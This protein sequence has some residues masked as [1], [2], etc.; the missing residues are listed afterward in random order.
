MKKIILKKK[1]KIKKMIFN[2]FYD[3]YILKNVK[4]SENLENYGLKYDTLHILE[5][6]IKENI[7]TLN[8][9]EVFKNVSMMVSFFKDINFYE[10]YACLISDN[11]SISNYV[12]HNY[13]PEDIKTLGLRMEDIIEGDIL[14]KDI[15]KV[16]ATLQYYFRLLF[17]KNDINMSQ[18]EKKIKES[19]Q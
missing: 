11:K 9:Q 4:I 7:N 17:N 1:N 10:K 16:N 15:N 6:E 2:I 5:K 12:S 19:I 3:A 14:N 18:F 13:Q 8:I